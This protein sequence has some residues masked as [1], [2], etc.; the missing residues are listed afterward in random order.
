MVTSTATNCQ[1]VKGVLPPSGTY[2]G[3][4]GGSCVHFVAIGNQ[5]QATTRTAIRTQSAPCHVTV[6]DDQIRVETVR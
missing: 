4:W 3:T 2:D 5:Y 6:T 1:Q